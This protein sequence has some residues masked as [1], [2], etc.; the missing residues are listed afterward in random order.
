[1]KLKIVS[2][3]V[4]G[5]FINDLNSA[6][7]SL[8]RALSEILGGQFKLGATF[9]EDQKHFLSENPLHEEGYLENL[10][11]KFVLSIEVYAHPAKGHSNYHVCY[12]SFDW[13]YNQLAGGGHN[14][15]TLTP[16]NDGKW[17]VFDREVG[18]F[19]IVSLGQEN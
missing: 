10:Y 4:V 6:S 18:E 17:L 14:G 13:T 7:E 8:D 1:M 9:K 3:E 15:V 11:E 16:Y 5:K 19:K 12:V 2:T